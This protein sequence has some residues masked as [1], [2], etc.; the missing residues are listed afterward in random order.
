[1]FTKFNPWREQW[2][3]YKAEYIL[4]IL[5]WSSVPFFLFYKGE[6]INTMLTMP[7]LNWVLIVFILFFLF[8]SLAAKV[9][10]LNNYLRWSVNTLD[11]RLRHI[12]NY[13]PE[14]AAA[15]IED[16]HAWPWGAHHTE[17]LAHLAAAAEKFWKN[18]DSADVT[19]APTNEMVSNWLR[20][21]RGVSK[22]K[23]TAIASILRA[24]GLRMG[25]RR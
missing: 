14:S 15:K 22:E 16:E 25:P 23:A 7:Y 5:G 21:E 18:Y 12:E 20:E 9:F 3:F 19:T 8:F 4:G 1:M 6:I 13:Q 11:A 17:A 24:D 10:T 2:K